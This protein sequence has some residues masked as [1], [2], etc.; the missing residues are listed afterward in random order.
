MYLSFLSPDAENDLKNRAL[1]NIIP[2]YQN[3]NNFD[4]LFLPKLK[5]LAKDKSLSVKYHIFFHF[6]SFV[7]FIYHILNHRNN[8]GEAIVNLLTEGKRER[9]T[10]I[11]GVFAEILQESDS[12]VKF[13]VFKKIKDFGQLE[14]TLNLN[15]VNILLVSLESILALKKWRM[16]ASVSTTMAKIV[17]EGKL[18]EDQFS[19]DFIRMLKAGLHDNTADVRKEAAKALGEI[20]TN[21][22]PRFV[23][24][25]ILPKFYELWQEPSYLIRIGAM[26]CIKEIVPKLEHTF[27]ET[28]LLTWISKAT[29]DPVPNIRI[30][31]IDTIVQVITTFAEKPTTINLY[32]KKLL[33]PLAVN[34]S[35]R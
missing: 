33:Q 14:S 4:T 20:A 10:G 18:R 35:D 25:N 21:F 3:I 6:D 11:D 8:L 27:V 32:K 12:E 31:A 24:T 16:R 5:A 15:I 26:F 17:V 29:Q 1:I 7:P 19:A 9:L 13:K 28:E 2:L 30:A 34:D 22:S 23:Q